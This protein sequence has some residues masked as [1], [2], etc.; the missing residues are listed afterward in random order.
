MI[1]WRVRV[2]NKA[3]WLALIPAILLLA[4]SVVALFGYD[5]QLGDTGDKLLTLVNNVFALLAILGIVNDPTTAG[6]SDS[7]LAMTYNAPK[8]EPDI[9][10]T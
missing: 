5:L 10:D 6:L 1:N 8:V 3:F 9:E 2:K 4:Q 7:Y